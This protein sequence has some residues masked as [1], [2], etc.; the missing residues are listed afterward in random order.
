MSGTSKVHG[1]PLSQ[2]EVNAMRAE[3]GEKILLSIKMFMLL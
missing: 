1:K 2:D 3:L